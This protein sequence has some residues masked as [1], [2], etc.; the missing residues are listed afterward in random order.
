MTHSLVDDAA[1]A[2]PW[3]RV[4]M[5]LK[6][7]LSGSLVVVALFLPPLGDALVGVVALTLMV[8]PARVPPR[9]VMLLAAAPTTF[10]LL[11]TIPIAFEGWP[12]MP[13]MAG[14]Q[15]AAALWVGSVA[16]TL[17]LLLFAT[18]TT[19]HALIT[20]LQRLRIPVELIDVASLTYR[21][22]F[23]TLDTALGLLAAHRARLGDAAPLRRRITTTASIASTM[24]IRTW[25]RMERLHDGLV[26]RGY[27]GELRTLACSPQGGRS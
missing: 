25:Q 19:L 10:L 17:A 12:P 13:T 24:F 18:T 6:L 9:T 15:R 4:P 11:G 1:W 20:G 8:G 22:L 21:I 23:V 2:S 5:S 26:G 3:R 7:L 16:G 27:E 14:A